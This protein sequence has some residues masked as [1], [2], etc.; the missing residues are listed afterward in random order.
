MG[1]NDWIYSPSESEWADLLVG[2]RIVEAVDQGDDAIFVLD[3]GQRIRVRGNEGCG[4]CANGYYYVTHIADVDN[5]ITA[6]RC[7]T[8]PV[9]GEWHEEAYIYRMFVITGNGE[10]E[11]LT[12]EGDDGN[13]YYGS[14]YSIE[15]LEAA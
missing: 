14:G 9:P 12:V 11:A 5:I 7:D 8:E 1:Y 15:I 6:V 13:G 2:H 10:I 3:D 4:G